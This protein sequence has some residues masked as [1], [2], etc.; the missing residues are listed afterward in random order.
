MDAFVPMTGT[1][2]KKILM[3]KKAVMPPALQDCLITI[4]MAAHC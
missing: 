3:E 2:S 4:T 1:N